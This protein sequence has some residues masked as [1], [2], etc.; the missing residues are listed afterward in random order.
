MITRYKKNNVRI[1]PDFIVNWMIQIFLGLR[2]LHNH[3]IIHR[4]LKPSNIFLTRNLTVKIGDFGVSRD[5]E[6]TL[7]GSFAGTCLYLAP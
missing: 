2:E 7:K 3:K 1:P 4:D 6:T 5:A